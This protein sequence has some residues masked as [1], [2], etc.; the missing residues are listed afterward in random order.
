MQVS[1]LRKNT[2]D[3]MLY[4]EMIRYAWNSFYLLIVM[5]NIKFNREWD[6]LMFSFKCLVWRLV[7]D[8]QA[9]F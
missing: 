7:K 2:Q 9:I 6:I 4:L 1:S 3:V 8:V 5:Y